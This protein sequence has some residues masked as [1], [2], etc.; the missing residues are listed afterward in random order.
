[1]MHVP[2][3]DEHF[4]NAVFLLRIAGCDRDVVHNAKP[5]SIRRPGMMSRRANQSESAR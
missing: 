5:H 1:M 4:A 2:I 3:D